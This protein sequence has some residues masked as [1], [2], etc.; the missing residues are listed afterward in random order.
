M[1]SRL[2]RAYANVILAGAD[3]SGD[4]KFKPGRVNSIC[5]RNKHDRFGLADRLCHVSGRRLDSRR[6]F[7]GRGG[8]LGSFG[9]LWGRLVGGSLRWGG[10]GS[11]GQESGLKIGDER[12]GYELGELWGIWIGAHGHVQEGERERRWKKCEM[13]W[14]FPP[15][16]LCFFTFYVFIFIFSYLYP[17]KKQKKGFAIMLRI[18]ITKYILKTYADLNPFPQLKIWVG[19]KLQMERIYISVSVFIFWI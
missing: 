16:F 9:L 5:T 2:R 17:Q 6:L 14:D 10:G 12:G 19:Y 11:T 13:V 18:I 7:D 3:E 8:N 4:E 1:N 15:D